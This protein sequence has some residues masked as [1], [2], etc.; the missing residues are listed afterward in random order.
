MIVSKDRS[1]VEGW[2]P[3]ADQRRCNE[4]PGGSKKKKKKRHVLEVNDE[5]ER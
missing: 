3:A 1:D 5:E 2:S 4:T